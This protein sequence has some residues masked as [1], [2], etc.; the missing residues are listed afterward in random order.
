MSTETV[1]TTTTASQLDLVLRSLADLLDAVPADRASAPTPCTELDV[2]A[3]RR[4]VLGW[5]TA[6]TDG[7]AAASGACSDPEAVTVVGTGGDQVRALADRL[8]TLLPAAAA[9]PLRIAGSAM[10]GGMALQMILWEYQVHGWDLAA[11]TGQPWQPDEAGL[12]ASLSFAPGMLTPD[13][14]GEGR[15]FAPPVPVPSSAPALDRLLGLSGRDPQ[16]ARTGPTGR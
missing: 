8:A 1:D 6:F 10:P 15:A 9:E 12:E 16:W 14:Q 11:A 5:L 4:H 13:F 7:Y 2:A 3:V